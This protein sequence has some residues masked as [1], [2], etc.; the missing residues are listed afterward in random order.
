M[1]WTELENALHTVLVGASGL[2]N[3][4]TCFSHLHGPAPQSEPYLRIEVP[5]FVQ[6]AGSIDTLTNASPSVPGAEVVLTTS[7]RHRVGVRV[8]VFGAGAGSLAQQI[9]TALEHPEVVDAAC[10]LG[11]S[12][13]D[14][15]ATRL[16]ALFESS[17]QDRAVVELTVFAWFD[18]SRTQTFIEHVYGEGTYSSPGHAPIVVPFGPVPT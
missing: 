18:Y 17:L 6:R 3:D 9:S 5:T 4:H 15:Q 16:P 7:G 11:L 2:A 13:T 8:H 1:T 12:I 14:A 10:A